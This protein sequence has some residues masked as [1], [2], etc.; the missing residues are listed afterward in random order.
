M[1][2]LVAATL[3]GSRDWGWKLDLLLGGKWEDARH[4]WL[5]RE[6]RGEFNSIYLG[7]DTG[8]IYLGPE[9]FLI[10]LGDK[11]SLTTEYERNFIA[12]IIKYIASRKTPFK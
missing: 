1:T 7:P 10:N 5:D 9:N 3:Q 4:K 2:V 11:S 8:S 6:Q 12:S